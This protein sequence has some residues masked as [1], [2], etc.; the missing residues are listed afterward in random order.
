M[1]SVIHKTNQNYFCM[2][3]IIKDTSN[4]NDFDKSNNNNK[5]Q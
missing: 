5:N 4:K 1:E 3:K 2:G